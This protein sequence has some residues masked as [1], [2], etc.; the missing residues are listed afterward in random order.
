MTVGLYQPVLPARPERRQDSIYPVRIKQ[1]I[2]F[3]S[4]LACQCSSACYKLS[5]MKTKPSP[6]PPCLKIDFHA[7][8]M[9]ALWVKIL[10]K[11][12]KK[13]DPI[14]MVEAAGDDTD[15]WLPHL[16]V[17]SAANEETF[18]MGSLPLSI[19][20][21]VDYLTQKNIVDFFFRI[22]PAENL[23]LLEVEYRLAQELDSKKKISKSDF[24]EW[25][26]DGGGSVDFENLG[27][28]ISK[29][30]AF[31]QKLSLIALKK[32][33]EKNGF[34]FVRNVELKVRHHDESFNVDLNE[35]LN[36]LHSPKVRQGKQPVPWQTKKALSTIA[37]FIYA[38]VKKQKWYLSEGIKSLKL[39]GT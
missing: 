26:A 38:D 1:S 35:S 24:R 5:Q 16:T 2:S 39:S 12:L 28:M 13:N 9:L 14:Q 3:R 19:P 7:A 4:A 25:V 20:A 37:T 10:R 17:K 18:T 27:A 32:E 23:E 21:I 31:E 22:E 11:D 6:K 8:K 33:L 15:I 30:I 36:Y 29:A 34:E